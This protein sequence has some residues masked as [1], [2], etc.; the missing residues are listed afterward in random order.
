MGRHRQV[1]QHDHNRHCRAFGA[2]RL[3]HIVPGAG[4][5]HEIHDDRIRHR[6]RN[7]QD[8]LLGVSRMS[9][10]EGSGNAPSI[11]TNSRNRIAESSTM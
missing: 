10:D 4:G 8:R 3:H 5:Q 1:R 6:F 2:Q 7:F 11:S 9:D